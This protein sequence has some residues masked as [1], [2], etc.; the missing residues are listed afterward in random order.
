MLSK[1]F[2]SNISCEGQTSICFDCNKLPYCTAHI[3]SHYHRAGDCQSK[4]GTICS[5][6]SHWMRCESCDGNKVFCGNHRSN[7]QH[8]CALETEDCKTNGN[9]KKCGECGRVFCESHSNHRCYMGSCSSEN[10]DCNI[11]GNYLVCTQSL[12]C[13]KTF[14]EKHMNHN[15]YYGACHFS[16]SECTVSNHLICS[17]CN[18][19]FCENH[20]DHKHVKRCTYSNCNNIAVLN[21][22]R[23]SSHGCRTNQYT[24]QMDDLS[25][26]DTKNLFIK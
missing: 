2:L 12:R 13:M 22:T 6:S 8:T 11:T 4:S 15:H 14:C 20:Q 26:M 17:V 3:N 16:N 7:H 18:K 1:C 5:S 24:T 19:V 23:C 10:K 25:I 21:T 9:Y